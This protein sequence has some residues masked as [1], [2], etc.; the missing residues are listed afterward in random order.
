MR[1]LIP[2]VREYLD[3]MSLPSEPSE[4][5]LFWFKYG[6]TVVMIRLFE[7]EDERGRSTFVRFVSTL[8]TDV[9]MSQA[10][11]ERVLNLNTEVLFGTFLLFPEDR[12]LAFAAT[13][14]GDKLDLEEFETALRYVARVSDDYDDVLQELAGGQ[15]AEDLL[16]EG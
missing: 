1:E 4:D 11:I 14:L 10:L 16:R 6:S 13:I 5:G 2:K 9:D 12:T 3:Q 7:N 15:R 8:L